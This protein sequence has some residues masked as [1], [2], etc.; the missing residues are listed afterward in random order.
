MTNKTLEKRSHGQSLLAKKPGAFAPK[1]QKSEEGQ[2]RSFAPVKTPGHSEDTEIISGLEKQIAEQAAEH[3]EKVTRLEKQLKAAGENVSVT[4]GELV[5]ALDPKT[6]AQGPFANRIGIAY[7]DEK[8]KSLYADVKA[9]G[10]NEIPG[11]VRP[12]EG[13]RFEVVYGHRRHQ[14]CLKANVPFY[15]VVEELSD[16][17]MLEKMTTENEDRE[18]LSPYELALRYKNWVDELKVWPNYSQLGDSIGRSQSYISQRISILSLPESVFVA[19]GDPRVLNNNQWRSLISLNGTDGEELASIAA[20]IADGRSE[21]VVSTEADVNRVFSHLLKLNTGTQNTNKVTSK[22]YKT[23][24]GRNVFSHRMNSGKLQITLDKTLPEDLQVKVLE[25]LEQFF[26][27][28]L[29]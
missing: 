3:L 4:D 8:F 1:K 27:E 28:N 21:F 17:E 13:N 16:K 2:T 22:K 19:L 9:K 10:R 20:E 11:K 6:V 26:Q 18:D 5:A 14:A 29:G 12:V 25:T 23:K 7:E 24:S 15:A